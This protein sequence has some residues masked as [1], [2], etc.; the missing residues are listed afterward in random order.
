MK[1]DLFESSKNC[2]SIVV[3]ASR[4]LFTL[5]VYLSQDYTDLFCFFSSME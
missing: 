4:K 3:L 1:S 2:P 5:K